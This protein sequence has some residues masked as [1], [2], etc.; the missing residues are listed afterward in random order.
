M[1]KTGRNMWQ[2]N[3]NQGLCINMTYFVL[4]YIAVA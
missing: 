2:T 4:V 1:A 3:N